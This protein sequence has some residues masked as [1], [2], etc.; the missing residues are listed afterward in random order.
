MCCIVPSDLCIFLFFLFEVDVIIS[1]WM[2]YFLLFESMLDTVLWARDRWLAPG[3]VILPNRCNISISGICDPD[4]YK[5]HV[6]YWSDVYGFKMSCM[7]SAVV[8]EASVQVIKSECLLT[9]ACVIKVS[10]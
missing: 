8:Q 5:N 1:E 7:R 4:L 9:D 2:G 10:D 6:S 3:G